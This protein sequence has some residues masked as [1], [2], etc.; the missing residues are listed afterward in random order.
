MKGSEMGKESLARFSVELR[1]SGVY[2]LWYTPNGWVYI[3]CSGRCIGNRFSW[4]TSALRGNYH[5]SPRLQECWDN[6]VLSDW[7]FA[8]IE[9]CSPD[10]CRE[11]EAYWAAQFEY[12][13]NDIVP[14][15]KRVTPHET[16]QK[17]RDGRSRFLDTPG[18]RED[19]SRR[20]VLQH[21][22]RRFGY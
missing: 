1:V 3:G 5:T 19:L 13:M 6:S 8:V 2:A 20:A 4:H 22:E 17:Q 15:E 21:K 7:E 14:G 11:R 10:V 18:A 12:L 9:E 16:R